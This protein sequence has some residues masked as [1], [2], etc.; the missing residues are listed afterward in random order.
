M[1][2][3]LCPSIMKRTV[4]LFVLFV[5]LIPCLRAHADPPSPAELATAQQ[6]TAPRFG[7]SLANGWVGGLLGIQ[8][9][10]RL[11]GVFEPT[12][13]VGFLPVTT[14]DLGARY[15][16]FMRKW[17]PYIGAGYWHRFDRTGSADYSHIADS[18]H[19]DLG[20][21]L[22]TERGLRLQLGATF[23][24]NPDS[25]DNAPAVL[26]LPQVNVGWLF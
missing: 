11:A 6:A 10:V 18:M 24:V 3:A 12:V 14:L 26:P 2:V 5:C 1:P 19:F 17:S 25:N 22:A 7:L 23:M 9:S 20:V 15:V 4:C 13:T 16:P 8:G 21:Q